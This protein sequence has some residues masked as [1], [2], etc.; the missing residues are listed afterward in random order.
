VQTIAAGPKLDLP[1]LWLHGDA[2]PLVPYGATGEA[3]ARIRTHKLE[4]KCYPGA[5]HEIFNET[6]RE[7]VIAD[8]VEFVAEHATLFPARHVGDTHLNR[9]TP[10]IRRRSPGA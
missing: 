1:T 8:A 10:L 5:M 7:E 6:N 2:D 4:H 3:I 9:A